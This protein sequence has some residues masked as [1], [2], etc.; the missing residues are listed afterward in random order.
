MV[1]NSVIFTAYKLVVE[2][3][4]YKTKKKKKEMKM[5]MKM[6]MDLLFLLLWW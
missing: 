6:K 3:V 4:S 1:H 2:P 5:K